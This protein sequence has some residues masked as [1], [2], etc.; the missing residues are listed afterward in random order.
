MK[1]SVDTD[2]FA[3]GKWSGSTPFFIKKVNLYQ[4]RGLSNLISLKLDVGLAS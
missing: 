4:Q 3:E 1:N 2:Q